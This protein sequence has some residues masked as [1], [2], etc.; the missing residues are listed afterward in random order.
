MGVDEGAEKLEQFGFEVVVR[1]GLLLMSMQIGAD[2]HNS[3]VRQ[4]AGIQNVSWTY[5]QSAV[6]ATLHL[7]EVSPGVAI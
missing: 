7:S 1:L 4:A 6:V 5:D 3:G 2:G